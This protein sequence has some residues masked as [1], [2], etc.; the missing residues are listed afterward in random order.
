M[1]I[2]GRFVELGP[3]VFKETPALNLQHH[4]LD[5]DDDAGVPAF[6]KVVYHSTFSDKGNVKVQTVKSG[7]SEDD[8][9]A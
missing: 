7:L 4:A 6:D 9:G 5:K 3:Q 2:H 1:E 8:S